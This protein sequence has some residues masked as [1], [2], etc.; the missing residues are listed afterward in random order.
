MKDKDDIVRGKVRDKRINTVFLISNKE[1][2]RY[3]VCCKQD[4]K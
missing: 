4:D 2:K 1:R 3:N